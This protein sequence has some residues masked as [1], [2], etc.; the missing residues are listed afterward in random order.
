MLEEF[1]DIGV[2]IRKQSHLG[3]SSYWSMLFF[4]PAKQEKMHLNLTS[5]FCSISGEMNRES[6]R[7][8]CFYCIYTRNHSES[9]TFD[10][11]INDLPRFVI[12]SK[13]NEIFD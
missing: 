5:K 7:N 2:G 11:I 9:G 4:D 8:L 3:I 10:G 1:I 6:L 12:H 13:K